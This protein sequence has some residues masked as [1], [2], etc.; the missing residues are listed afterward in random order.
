MSDIT[1]DQL[2]KKKQELIQERDHKL[3]V[4]TVGYDNAIALLDELIEMTAKKDAA[5]G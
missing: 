4:L 5:G 1:V 3:L 2:L